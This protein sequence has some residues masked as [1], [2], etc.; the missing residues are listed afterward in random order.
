MPSDRVGNMAMRLS[1]GTRSCRIAAAA[2]ALLFVVLDQAP[3]IGASYDVEP[4]GVLRYRRNS[5]AQSC[6]LPTKIVCRNRTIVMPTPQYH[7]SCSGILFETC[8]QTTTTVET[9]TTDVYCF[10]Q[11]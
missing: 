2:A 10:C 4:S 11:R 7:Q 8:V 5:G 9:P 3:V 1:P 6:R